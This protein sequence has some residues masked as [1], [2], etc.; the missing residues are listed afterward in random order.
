MSQTSSIPPG[1]CLFCHGL[2]KE[3]T[4]VGH[5]SEYDGGGGFWFSGYCPSCDIDFRLSVRNGIFDAWKPD[6]PQVS[7][8]KSAVEENELVAISAKLQR[9]S[10]L[11]AKWQTF[12]SR[13]RGGDVVWRFGS[14]DTNPKGFAVVR[15]GQPVSRFVV[16]SS[17]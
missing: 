14:A 11:G 10:I 1:H 12:L 16:L 15:C 7:E 2:I 9:Y 13:R 6:G 17:M 3:V 5:W 4:R 8:L